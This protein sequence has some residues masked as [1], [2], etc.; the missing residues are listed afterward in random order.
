[1][2]G[3]N[4]PAVTPV[5]F[6]TMPPRPTSVD[7]YHTLDDYI[8]RYDSDDE[9]NHDPDHTELAAALANPDTVITDNHIATLASLASGCG[10]DALFISLPRLHPPIPSKDRIP[11]AAKHFC[12]PPGTWHALFGRPA[13]VVHCARCA[14]EGLTTDPDIDPKTE[15]HFTDM[16]IGFHRFLS[17]FLDG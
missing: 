7:V 17:L 10:G 3:L 15:I 6:N 13:P 8:G 9:D 1:M 11:L 16:Q 2:R 12:I 4:P 14:A 5:I